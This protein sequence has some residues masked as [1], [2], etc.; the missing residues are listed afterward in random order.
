MQETDIKIVEDTPK[1]K[2]VIWSMYSD[3]VIDNYVWKDLYELH[4]ED[5]KVTLNV[6]NHLGMVIKQFKGNLVFNQ[7]S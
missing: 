7:E 3:K 1:E 5:D 2:R 6:H 4:V